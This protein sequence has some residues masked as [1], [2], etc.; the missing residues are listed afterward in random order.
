MRWSSG[1]GGGPP[2]VAGGL[3][4][5]IAPDGTLYG[6]DPATGSVRR[7]ASI[8]R[9]DNHFPTPAVGDGLLLAPSAD[10]VVAFAATAAGSPTTVPPPTT[11]SP[12]RAHPVG[13]DSGGLPAASSPGRPWPVPSRSVCPHGCSGA[14]VGA[15]V[16]PAGR[17]GVVNAVAAGPTS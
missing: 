2:I 13:A 7:Q 16:A 4:W 12:A 15:C 11:T 17:P 6:L 9:P 1:A 5:T 3:V 10:R 8:G 14:A